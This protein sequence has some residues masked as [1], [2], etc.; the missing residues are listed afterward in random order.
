M[1]LP[2]G[3][4]P[5]PYFNIGDISGNHKRICTKFSGIFLITRFIRFW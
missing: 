2:P 4:A 5:I 1:L 3:A